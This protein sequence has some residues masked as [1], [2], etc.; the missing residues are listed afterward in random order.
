ML[1]LLL[2]VQLLNLLHLGGFVNVLVGNNCGLLLDLA[3]GPGE[4]LAFALFGLLDL[5]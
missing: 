3:H 1:F 4:L 5:L 2:T